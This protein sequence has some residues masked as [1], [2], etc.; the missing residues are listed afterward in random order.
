MTASTVACSMLGL[1]QLVF[2]PPKIKTL[3]NNNQAN[4]YR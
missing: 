1:A 2:S 4:S 3:I